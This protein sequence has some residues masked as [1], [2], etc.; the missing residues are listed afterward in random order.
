[1]LL[2][3][4]LKWR[5]KKV[6]SKKHHS[7]QHI[8][9]TQ[10]NAWWV[11]T[12]TFPECKKAETLGGGVIYNFSKLSWHRFFCIQFTWLLTKE[13]KPRLILIPTFSVS[14]SPKFSVFVSQGDVVNFSCLWGTSR[15]GNFFI[16]LLFPKILIS[17]TATIL[18]TSY[19]K[20]IVCIKDILNSKGF[21]LIKIFLGKG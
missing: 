18:I 7:A 11:N 21:I 20:F 2:Q 4:T 6:A 17:L 5:V 13:K 19:T 9:F 12:Q 3:L 16:V 15:I 14:P 10:R 1:M 8:L